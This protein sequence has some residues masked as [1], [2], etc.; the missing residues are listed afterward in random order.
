MARG[1]RIEL[2]DREFQKLAEQTGISQYDLQ[3]LYSMGLLRDRGV[4]NVLMRYD[5]HKISRFGKY[6]PGQIYSRLAMFY[7]IPKEN[8]ASTIYGTNVSK[9]FCG[10]CGKLIKKS[11]FKRN[12]GICDECVAKSIEIP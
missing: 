4:M 6:T 7:H 8:I 1:L 10:E 12:D 5:Y 2:T 11:E 3:K 9:Y